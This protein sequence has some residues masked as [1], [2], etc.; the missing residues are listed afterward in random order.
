MA[1]MLQGLR[2]ST[3]S[4]ES[5]EESGIVWLATVRTVGFSTRSIESCE[6]SHGR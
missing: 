2:F 3:R 1:A 6:E 4:I 5:C